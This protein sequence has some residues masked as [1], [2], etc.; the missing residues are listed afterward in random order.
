VAEFSITRC[1]HQGREPEQAL[2]RH[3]GAAAGEKA[4][5]LAV[6]WEME[7]YWLPDKAHLSLSALYLLEPGRAAEAAVLPAST[8]IPA[9]LTGPS[10]REALLKWLHSVES[11]L[12]SSAE[13]LA[14]CPAEVP[15]P[16]GREL[17]YTGIEERGVSLLA[18]PGGRPGL[19]LPQLLEALPKRIAG[20]QP[21][22]Q[23]LLKILDPL[24]E[25]VYGDLYFELHEEKREVYVMLRAEP[26]AWPDGQGRIRLG[27]NRAERKKYEDD[28]AFRAA[29]LTAVQ[30]Y[31][32]VRRRIDRVFDQYRQQ[33]GHAENTPLPA[34]LLRRWQRRLPAALNTLEE[35]KRRA[36]ERFSELQLLAPG[37]VVRVPRR[38]PHALQHGVRVVEFQT[39]VYERQI[40]SF[41]QKVL[42]QEYWDSEEAVR[43]MD[44]D[45]P[46]EPPQLLEEGAGVRV[47]CIADFE[48]FQARR[49]CLEAGAAHRLGTGDYAAVAI[50][51]LGSL[52]LG[53]CTLAAEEACLLPAAWPG[54]ILR[55]TG[56]SSAILLVA[57]PREKA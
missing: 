1:P 28:N 52:S 26:T 57:V 17:W 13:P 24:P 42:T 29:F 55:N 32:A 39:P 5:L 48:D 21:R 38:T 23:V 22:R 51:A 43:R 36:M 35:E 41:A 30:D 31:E 40:I 46:R 16:W 14:L 3:L 56:K 44:L 20:G 25:E 49:I 50:A 34:A 33:E 27:F 53:D 45:A 2:E 15:K 37:E 9:V 7:Q 47:E 11:S 19:P 12:F 10:P 54:D 18:A 4:L 8:E 6:P